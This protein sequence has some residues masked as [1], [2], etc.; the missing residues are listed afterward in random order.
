LKSSPGGGAI[1]DPAVGWKGSNFHMV[2]AHSARGKVLV[3]AVAAVVMFLIYEASIIDPRA[4][5]YAGAG[6]LSRPGERAD[7]V[8]TAYCKGQTT[9]S[10]ARV[11]AGVAAA[12]PEFLPL[13][14]VISVDGVA[15]RYRGIYTVLDTGPKIKGRRLD[16]YIWS[17]HEALDF[18]KRSVEV[19][20]LR[21][22]WN[23]KNTAASLK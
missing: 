22:G 21:L 20:V 10:G 14:S 1:A 15:D 23:P 4:I 9:A 3:G 12:D 5:T 2:L 17:C 6:I 8:A 18:G 13:G 7:F 19:T 11:K 16:L